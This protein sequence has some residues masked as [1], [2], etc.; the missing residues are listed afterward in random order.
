MR[1]RWQ[2]TALRNL[3]SKTSHAAVSNLFTNRPASARKLS[4]RTSWSIKIS[5]KDGTRL[6]HKLSSKINKLDALSKT[7]TSETWK[8]IDNYWSRDFH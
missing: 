8:R 2:R 6:L 7:D 5:T 4:R 1:Q 3:K